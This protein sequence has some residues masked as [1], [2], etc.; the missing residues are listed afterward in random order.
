[1][2]F[3]FFSGGLPKR[4]EPRLQTFSSCRGNSSET[5]WQRLPGP[6]GQ[7]AA[8]SERA[9]K[10][11]FV[12]SLGKKKTMKEAP[13]AKTRFFNATLR[14][15]QQR[16]IIK[17]KKKKRLP[18][19]FS[20]IEFAIAKFFGFFCKLLMPDEESQQTHGKPS[21]RVMTVHY[22]AKDKGEI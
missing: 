15:Q 2:F 13:Q 16:I 6:Q 8:A 22:R 5:N 21:L 7:A 18:S 12:A 11:L 3:W 10:G 19:S 14:L 4:K 1:M 9:Q 20:M 17:K